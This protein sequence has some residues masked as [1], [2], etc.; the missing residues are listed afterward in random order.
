VRGLPPA[1]GVSGR[2]GAGA[3]AQEAGLA[4]DAGAAPRG[5]PHRPLKAKHTPTGRQPRATKPNAWWG[6]DMPTLV[7]EDVR[8]ALSWW[9]WLG[10]PSRLAVTTSA[11]PAPPRMG[12]RL[13]T[14]LSTVSAPMARG[15]GLSWMRDHGCQP[16][17][18]ALRQACHTLGSQQALTS[19]TKPKG[20]AKT[21]RM[22]RTLNEEWLW[23][24]AWRRPAGLIRTLEAWIDSDHAPSWHSSLGDQ[25]PR[26][27]EREDH[28]RHST[29]FVA[30]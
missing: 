18:L 9:G 16:T 10:I 30:A 3:G 6:I 29:P 4:P 27:C 28:H 17:S 13:W 2:R 14:G 19:D 7:G 26:P 21:E 22:R 1:L 5:P 12:W 24:T 20:H 25:T 15:Q 11:R 8:G 23:R